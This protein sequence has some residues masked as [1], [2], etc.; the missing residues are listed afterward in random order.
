MEIYQVKKDGSK[1]I[2]WDRSKRH[3][4]IDR[5]YIFVTEE[6][7][8]RIK[9]NEFLE[10]EYK[11]N[12]HISADNARQEI[13]LNKLSDFFER[14][15]SITL[16]LKTYCYAQFDYQEQ[17]TG[18]VCICSNNQFVVSLS[19]IETKYG[20]DREVPQWEQ[21]FY[22]TAEGLNEL[23]EKFKESI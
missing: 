16:E 6:Q 15:F 20:H 2:Q 18:Y 23:V 7:I 8:Q 14:T 11:G 19:K 10:S 1:L 5:K 17:Y 13:I 4:E 22:C 3:R 12:Y 9:K 21:S